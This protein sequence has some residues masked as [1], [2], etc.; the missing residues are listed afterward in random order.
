[1]AQQILESW[2]GVGGDETRATLGLSRR[3]PSGRSPTGPPG[4]RPLGWG[5]RRG[6]KRT[7]GI[8]QLPCF[9]KVMK[10]RTFG[11][12]PG[13]TSYCSG[14]WPILP[15]PR[16][17]RSHIFR[18]QV[19]EH[20]AQNADCGVLML[21]SFW[22]AF[23]RSQRDSFLSSTRGKP[24]LVLGVIVC[25][26]GRKTQLQVPSVLYCTCKSLVFPLRRLKKA[27][28]RPGW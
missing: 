14:A 24:L 26:F 4:P 23:G 22:V 3:D 15:G 6:R 18:A 17:R 27:R 28:N 7:I 8:R 5:N 2:D 12:S 9:C 10:I 11:V 13:A 25:K 1:M 19:R 16:R 21:V 20:F